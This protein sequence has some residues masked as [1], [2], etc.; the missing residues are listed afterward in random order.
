[1]GAWWIRG[2][3]SS[4]GRKG[5]GPRREGRTGSI[6]GFVGLTWWVV[7]CVVVFTTAGEMDVR[8]GLEVQGLVN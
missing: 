6:G 8:G 5:Q 2:R 1:M 4:L 3:R 7:G